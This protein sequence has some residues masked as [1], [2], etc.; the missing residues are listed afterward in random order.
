MTECGTCGEAH[1]CCCLCGD[2][3]HPSWLDDGLPGCE[4]S[5][6]KRVHLTGESALEHVRD[7]R[8]S[9]SPDARSYDWDSLL[10]C[11]GCR[12]EFPGTG[13]LHVASSPVPRD[14]RRWV[15]QS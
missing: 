15:L 3:D 9:G 8:A 2:D 14:Q 12:R 5:E 10:A 1:E 13:H 7:L 4:A 6:G 11:P